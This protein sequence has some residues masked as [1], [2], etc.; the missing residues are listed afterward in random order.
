[1][2]C[3]CHDVLHINEAVK[4]IVDEAKEFISEPSKDEL[5]DIVYGMNRLI[6]AFLKMKYVKLIP[7]DGIHVKKIQLRMQEYGCI[8]SE[9]HLL[10]S[11][12]PSE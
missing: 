9:R 7:G 4:G 10:N 12:C 1:M 11:K 2:Y 5:S 6:G 8:R 3:K